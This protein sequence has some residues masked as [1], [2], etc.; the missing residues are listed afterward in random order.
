MC[1]SEVNAEG[2]ADYTLVGIELDLWEID[3]NDAKELEGLVS[4]GKVPEGRKLKDQ[5]L[6][7]RQPESQVDTSSIGSSFLYV[8]KDQGIGVVVLTDF[9]VTAQDVTGLAVAPHGVGFYRGVQID[10][11]QI[12]R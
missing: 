11:Q 10:Y 12:A 6:L 9:V 1:V 8:T 2:V 4:K 3:P 7:H 5:R